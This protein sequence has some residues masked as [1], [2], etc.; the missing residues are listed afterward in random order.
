MKVHLLKGYLF[1]ILILIFTSCIN[2]QEIKKTENNYGVCLSV[3]PHLAFV[4][5]FRLDID[6]QLGNTKGW[7]VGSFSY[8]Q[9]ESDEI[10]SYDYDKVRVYGFSGSYRYYLFKVNSPR[11]LYVQGGVLVNYGEM[12]KY[13]Y[14]WKETT[15]LGTDAYEYAKDNHYDKLIKTGMDLKV[16]VVVKSNRY[17]FFDFYLGVGYRDVIN[18]ENHT[19]IYL[20]SDF[21]DPKYEGFVPLLGVRFGVN[22]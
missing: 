5:R 9:R 15:Y 21:P 14:G 12:S 1:I 13:G 3:T 11:F 2:G 7:M 18:L 6:K 10:M 17:I 4:G 22:L 20:N 16:G 19:G 8:T